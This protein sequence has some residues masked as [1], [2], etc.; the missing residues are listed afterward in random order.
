MHR[1]YRVNQTSHKHCETL[2]HCAVTQNRGQ[3]CAR[4]G[5]VY[6][7]QLTCTVRGGASVMLVDYTDSRLVPPLNLYL[8]HFKGDSCRVEGSSMLCSFCD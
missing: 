6:C 5:A 8:H 3:G 4:K 7:H 2:K 1:V